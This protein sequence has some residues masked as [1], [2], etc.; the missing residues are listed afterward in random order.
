MYSLCT[1]AACIANMNQLEDRRDFATMRAH[2]SIQVNRV[3]T[4]V[5]DYHTT[6]IIYALDGLLSQIPDQK[7]L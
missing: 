5:G 2:N 7:E 3:H 4:S 6:C 1:T